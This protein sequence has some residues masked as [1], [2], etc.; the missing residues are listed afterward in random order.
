M[1]EKWLDSP[2]SVIG[3]WLCISDGLFISDWSFITE[4]LLINDWSLIIDGLFAVTN[5]TS[6][7]GCFS[8][9]L[10]ISDFV[11]NAYQILFLY[12]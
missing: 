2:C 12:Q 11:D 5:C 10:F 7:I 8:D 1:A 9:E 3:D 6:L 4:R